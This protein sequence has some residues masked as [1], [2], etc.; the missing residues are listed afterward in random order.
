MQIRQMS[1][2]RHQEVNQRLEKIWGKINE[3]SSDYAAQI[4]RLKRA[5]TT[6]PLWAFD[7]RRGR[8]VYYRTCASCH[9]LDGSSAPLGPKLV[10]SWCNGIDSFLENIIDPNPSSAR[11]F[12]P[13]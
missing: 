4:E 6:A 12:A 5:Y 8:Q 11:V 13:R 7:H 1:N 9:P 10:G 3:S 2:L